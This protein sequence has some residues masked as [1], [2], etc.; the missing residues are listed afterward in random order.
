MIRRASV[1]L[2]RTLAIISVASLFCYAQSQS[3]PTRHTRDVVVTGE[4]QSLGRLPANQTMHLDVMLALRHEPELE[5]FLEELYDPSSSS[6]RH[7][8][9]VE[10]FTARFGPSQED[11]NALLSFAKAN[12]FRVTG[13][14]ARNRMVVSIEGTVSSVEKAFHVKMGVYQHPTE[15][16]TFYAPD[17]EPSV[18][19]PF[20]LWHVDGLDNFSIPRPNLIRTNSLAKSNASVGSGPGASFLGSDMRAAYYGTGSL[21]GAGQ[22]LGLFELLGTDLADLTTYYTNVHQTLNVPITLFSVGGARTSCTEPNCDDTEQTLDMTQALGMAPNLASLVMYIGNTETP[23]FNAMATA[24]PLNA[25][26]SCSWYW[27]PAD[28]KTLDP[29][30][31]EFATQ[32]QNLFDAAGDDHDWQESGSIWPADDAYLVSV[33][34]TD[35]DTQSAGGPWK[36]ETV[37]VDGGG[38][39]SPNNIPIPSWQ[40]ATAA[41]CSK[42][43]QTLRNGPDVAANSNFT[44]YVCA[45]QTTCTENDYGGTSFAAPMWAGYLALANQQGEAAGNQPL[46]FIN[47]A[48]Y[49]IGLSGSYTTDFHDITSGSNGYTATTGYDLATGWGSPNGAA[50]IN[51]LTVPAG[52]SFSLTANPTSVSVQ[53]GSQATSA[54]TVV[55][56]DGFSGSVTL[57]AS[58][59]PSGVT[60]AFNPNPTST[61][62]TLTFTASGTAATGT[63][64]VTVSGTSGSLSA[65]TTISLTVTQAAGQPVVT[66][67]PTSLTFSK[68]AVGGTSPAKTITLSNTGTG[69]LNISSIVPSGDFAIS[70]NTCGSTVAASKSCKIKV[71][72]TPTQLGT[73]T[74]AITITDNAGGSP[75]SVPLT[76]TGSVQAT[77]TPASAKFA[78]TAVG[79]TSAAKT[80]TLANKQKTASLTGISPST[81]GEFAISATTCGSTLAA[82]SKC[83]ISVVFKP[84]QTGTLTGALQVSDNAVGSPQV[85]SLSGTGK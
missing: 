17:R 22:T 59:L 9:T 78:K 35:L 62:S 42:C 67:S 34:G 12:G 19:L 53:Q 6:Y 46:G 77:L 37:W 83:T 55:P 73:R 65:Q 82:N 71:T 2:L 38:G 74:G 30:F 58:G 29:I 47:P 3:F 39:I 36:S 13:D 15:N 54:I 28:P 33:G 66:L 23:I 72:F 52:P 26:L 4:A 84:T 41:G 24:N 5:N 50:L 68:E 64:T 60:A 10:E 18:D 79:A 76:G 7:F 43:S 85:S 14:T 69:T 80:F 48:L 20:Q 11:Y 45:D 8:L 31:Q 61:T 57:S 56:S 81:T 21:N 1:F 40:V 63:T 49:T 25:Q 75:Q 70:S 16:R 27:N 51:A 32:G 44:F